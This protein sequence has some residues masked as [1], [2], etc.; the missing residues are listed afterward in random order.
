MPLEGLQLG[1]YRLTHII[2]S[3]GMG[4][5]YVGEDVGIG[6]QVAVKVMRAEPSSY[7]EED[8][9]KHGERLFQREMK[10]VAML[11]HPHIL[12]LFDYGEELLHKTTLMYMVMP[13]R[14]E[15]SF[16]DWLR[17][18]T[19]PLSLQEI[20]YFLSQ[21][22]EAL[23]HAHDHQIVHQDVKPSNFLIRRKRTTTS[24]PDLLLADFGIARISNL[25]SSVS[26]SSI[27]G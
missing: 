17:Q 9:L 22:A 18:R 19:N 2:G 25:T 15:G 24:L 8:A 4:D 14:Q 16:A 21:A 5:V 26:H 7:P 27:V 13:F 23:Q 6:R 20:A 12:P 1:K 11:D 3:G 10:A